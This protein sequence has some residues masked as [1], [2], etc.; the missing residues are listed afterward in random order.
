M[1]QY[2]GVAFD[3]QIRLQIQSLL[4]RME[5]DV[6]EPNVAVADEIKDKEHDS[7]MPP[8]DLTKLEQLNEVIL[9]TYTVLWVYLK[10]SE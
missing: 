9:C 7:V 8:H 2:C 4:H 10:N 5:G 3:G 1:L 6:S